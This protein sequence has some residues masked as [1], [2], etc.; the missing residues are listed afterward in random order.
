MKKKNRKKVNYRLW[1][2]IGAPI[3]LS[4][5]AGA[6]GCW[7]FLE[8]LTSKFVLCQLFLNADEKIFLC[9]LVAMI[10]ATA[11]YGIQYLFFKKALS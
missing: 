6:G 10:A 8:K 11:M 7:F 1:L 9:A 2:V 3:F 5:C 4:A